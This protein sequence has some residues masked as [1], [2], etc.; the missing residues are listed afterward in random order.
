MPGEDDWPEADRDKD[1]S[2]SS[3]WDKLSKEAKRDIIIAYA[4]DHG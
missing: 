3:V 4:K 1:F 2:L